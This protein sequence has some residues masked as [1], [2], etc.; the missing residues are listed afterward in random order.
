MDK[1]EIGTPAGSSPTPQRV[2]AVSSL[3]SISPTSLEVIPEP[4]KIDFFDAMR[5]VSKGIRVT[6]LEWGDPE[7]YV[8]LHD[9]HLSLHKADGRFFDLI[10][11]AGDMLG[12]DWI[13][14]Q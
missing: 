2:R 10:V 14:I 11:S 6:K 9:S 8:M 4:L 13:V 3:K 1:D 12:T 5:M 7:I